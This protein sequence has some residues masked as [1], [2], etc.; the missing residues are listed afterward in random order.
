M[1][2]K[3][4][5]EMLENLQGQEVIRNEKYLSTS[6]P[7]LSNPFFLEIK[8]ENT[9]TSVEATKGKDSSAKQSSSTKETKPLLQ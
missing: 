7:E 4:N 3:I 5:K 1:Q 2:V 6:T 8:K 9:P